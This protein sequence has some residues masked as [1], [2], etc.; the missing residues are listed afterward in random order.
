[1]LNI[2][3]SL[4][5]LLRDSGSQDGP[6]IPPRWLRARTGT[7]EA[8]HYA[9]GGRAALQELEG[10][11]AHTGASLQDARSVLDFGCGS[12]RVLSVLAE[13]LPASRLQGCDVDPAAIGWAS[14]HLP[15]IGWTRSG[16]LP[17]LPFADAS[18]EL[19]YSLSVLSHLAEADQDSWLVELARLLA[20][21]ATA[22]LSVHGPFA[23]DQFRKGVASTAWCPPSAFARGPLG[24]DEFVFEP[25]ARSLWN[26]AELGAIEGRFGL[27]FHGADYVRR[28]WPH[29]LEV[30]TI[31]P[32]AVSEWQDLV[33]C[34]KAQTH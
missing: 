25:Y 10:A 9:E 28:H 21:G 24:D 7:A 27:A 11:L 17:P 15:P 18:F 6:P 26:R 34:T 30:V 33:V 16:F 13:R 4:A 5:G 23:F 14:R 8:L 19:I 2:G 29:A 22:L 20:P 32:R 3:D 12:G 31:L 1:V